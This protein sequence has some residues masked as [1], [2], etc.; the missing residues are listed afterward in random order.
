MKIAFIVQRY[1]IEVVGGSESLCRQV[2]EHLVKYHTIEVLTTCARNYHSWKNEYSEGV[3][4]INKVIIRRFKVEKEFDLKKFCKCSKRVFNKSHT[5]RDECKWI[6]EQGPYVPRLLEFIKLHNKEYD[7][8]VFFTYR[9]YPSFFGL[10]LVSEKSILVPTAEDEPTLNLNVNKAFF[11]LP[12]AFIYVT[13]EEK[14]L[15]TR[16]FNNQDIP[17]III[18]I[19][20]TIPQNIEQ[21]RFSNRYHSFPDYI[22]YIGRIDSNK[23]CYQLFDYYQH[24]VEDYPSVPDLILAGSESIPIPKHKKIHYIGFVSESEKVSLLANTDVL[25]MPSPFESLSLVTLE[26]MAS[27]V[28]ILVNGDCKVLRGHCIRSNGGLWYQNYEEFKEC[29]IYLLTNT[30]ARKKMGLLGIRYAQENYSWESVEKKYLHI[31]EKFWDE[32]WN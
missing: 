23:G 1:G 6:E 12:K 2:A 18:G 31:L 21:N 19:G 26:A 20:L 9:Y 30:D 22:L 4:E 16:Q 17:N 5:E 27:G 7:L 14:Q 32:K 10:P 11:H 25:V 15:I 13:K 8:F 3:E 28:S 29:L 24:L